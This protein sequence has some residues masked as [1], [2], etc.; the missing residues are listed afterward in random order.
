MRHLALLESPEAA[1]YISVKCR[2]P[3]GYVVE[4]AGIRSRLRPWRHSAEAVTAAA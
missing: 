3:D 2:D 1:E 4:A